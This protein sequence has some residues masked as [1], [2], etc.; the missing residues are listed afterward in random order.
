[1]AIPAGLPPVQ[2]STGAKPAPPIVLNPKVTDI[3]AD[4]LS[5]QVHDRRALLVTDAKA[6]ALALAKTAPSGGAKL[7]PIVIDAAD[8]GSTA[9]LKGVLQ[10]VLQQ[11]KA[12]GVDISEVKPNDDL[13]GA[14]HRKGAEMWTKDNFR[15]NPVLV[16]K[17][18]MRLTEANPAALYALLDVATGRIPSSVTASG[19]SNEFELNSPGR[20][21]VLLDVGS[22]PFS[23][24]SVFSGLPKAQL[25][26]ALR[27]QAPTS[28]GSWVK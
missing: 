6:T 16:I 12:G 18:A 24:P 9:D 25:E 15:A 4:Q 2:G 7:I 8:L 26:S 3:A 10:K 20:A 19:K 23:A 17:N 21:R 13:W 27:V 1:M 28:S 5:K 11:L 22:N 14:M